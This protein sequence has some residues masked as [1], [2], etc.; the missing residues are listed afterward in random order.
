MPAPPGL[1]FQRYDAAGARGIH[2]TV[3]LIHRE[4]YVERIKSGDP[5]SADE[6]FMSRFDSYTKI[7][8]FEMILACV[9]GQP[10]GQAWGW[11]LASDTEWW[12]GLT[13]EP[14]SGFTLE[15][16]TRTFALS[17]LMV[18]QAYTGKRIARALHDEMLRGRPEDRATLLVNPANQAAYDIYR[19]WGWYTVAQLRPS[20]PGAPLFDVL[21][22]PL[23][24]SE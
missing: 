13:A 21:I 19:R 3:S 22:L 1:H 17:E 4:A 24:V 14:E 9:D 23:P 10:A 18:C 20:W 16:G 7:A 8:G 2:D 5:F 12:D 6:A 11:P 15:D